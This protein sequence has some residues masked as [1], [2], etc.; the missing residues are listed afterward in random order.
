MSVERK[1]TTTRTIAASVQPKQL[2]PEQHEL[3]KAIAALGGSGDIGNQLSSIVGIKKPNRLCLNKED[4]TVELIAEYLQQWAK[5]KCPMLDKNMR[6]RI[7]EDLNQEGD[8][9]PSCTVDI[10]IF[11]EFLSH[12][13]FVDIIAIMW[14]Y[15]DHI[16]EAWTQLSLMTKTKLLV[17]LTS[18]MSVAFFSRLSS[19]NKFWF[20]QMLDDKTV[21]V[22]QLNLTYKNI[23]SEFERVAKIEQAQRNQPQQEVATQPQPQQDLNM[24]IHQ[25]QEAL[26]QQTHQVAVEQQNQQFLSQQAQELHNQLQRDV[27]AQTQPQPQQESIMTTSVPTTTTTTQPQPNIGEY[28]ELFKIAA[29]TEKRISEIKATHVAFEKKT[30]ERFGGLESRIAALE[31]KTSTTTETTKV[32]ISSGSSKDPYVNE[33]VDQVA[34]VVG[35]GVA[36]GAVVYAGYR[37][38]KML[39]GD[40]A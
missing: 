10:T 23:E 15:F 20:S 35:Y 30:E 2:S 3:G 17:S 40:D 8:P 29:E 26:Q 25:Q 4:F 12:E 33:T 31:K 11:N 28:A 19:T 13:D 1:N 9:E 16:V 24:E 32:V 6:E 37:I 5:E 14:S 22:G 21:F 39:S 34:T 38:F 27:A 36:G 18:A 7:L